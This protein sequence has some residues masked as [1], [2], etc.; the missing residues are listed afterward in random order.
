[1]LIEIL[2]A[3]FVFSVLSQIKL[4]SLD[5]TIYIYAL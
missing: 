4:V 3:I 2:L 1:M 5:L